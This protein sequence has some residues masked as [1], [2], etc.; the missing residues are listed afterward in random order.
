[1]FRKA[2][3]YYTDS[4]K[5][6][7]KEIWILSLVSLIN[8]AGTMVIPFLSLYLTSDVGMSMAQVGW[9]MTVFGVGSLI[10]SWLGGKL[11]DSIGFYPTML[12]SLMLSGVAFIALQY[13][14]T[15][16]MF[17]LAILVLMI[18][19]DTFRPALFVSLRSY[20]K[21]ENRT[22]SVTLIRLAI[23]L[24]FS[25]GPAIGGLIIATIGY[26]GLFWVDGLTCIV[27]GILIL[28]LL[29]KKE[30]EEQVQETKHADSELR[31][32]YKDKAYLLFLVTV[33]LVGITFLQYFSTVPLYYRD[34]HNLSEQSIG[35]LLA[36]NGV[37]IFLVEMPLVK[38]IE[39]FGWSVYKTLFI[40]IV[41]LAIS[42]LVYNLVPWAGI[43]L[44][45][46][47]LMTV[48]EMINFPFANRFAMD[49]SDT[50]KAGSY[51]ALYTIAFSIA[52]II[53]HNAG[54]Q[55]IANFGYEFTWYVAAGLLV[56]AAVITL[57]LK[58]VVDRESK[59]APNDG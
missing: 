12:W 54:L 13:V 35:L 39:D 55:S 50:G 16:E 3:T 19:L 33:L 34:V 43:L 49:R 17:C 1:M 41:L 18:I 44:V 45:G 47:V 20:S 46:M 31:S 7:R 8:R 32:P 56:I 30:S 57:Y 24:G 40:S 28:L 27:A 37:I 21:P 14:Q 36:L 53:G 23:N 4:F 26:N 38:S 52:H 59:A 15:F 22:R 11:S 51:M 48:G 6:F 58:V 29:D 5:G 42:F 10:G 9:V 25:A 2:L